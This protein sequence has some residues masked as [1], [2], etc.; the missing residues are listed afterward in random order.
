MNLSD[1]QPIWAVFKVKVKEFDG[2]V[3]KKA[4]AALLDRWVNEQERLL[5]AA[6]RFYLSQ[7]V[8]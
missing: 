1:H 2:E 4:K 5:V 6:L 8:L 3:R 7:E